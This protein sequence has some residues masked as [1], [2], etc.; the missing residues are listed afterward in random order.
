MKRKI[1]FLISG[2]IM[3]V[4]SLKSM[5][6][7]DEII[8]SM[9]N[10]FSEVPG[11]LGERIINLFQNSGYIYVFGLAIITIILNIIIIYFASKGKIVRYKELVLTF[12]IICF[13]MSLYAINELLAIINI[14]VIANTKRV[15]KEDFPEKKEKLPVL[16]K[17]DITSKKIVYAVLL[18]G[19]YFSQFIWKEFIPDNEIII[20]LTEILFYVGMFL[21]SIF[22]FKDL[23]KDNFKIFTSKFKAYMQYLL[24][25]I[26]KFYLVY[27]GISILVFSLAGSNITANQTSVEELPLFILIP[28]AII[29]APLV[30][31]CLFRGCIRRF[32]KNDKLFIVISAISF[33]L[34]HT[35][36]SEDTIYMAFVMAIP[37]ATL[38]GFLAYLYTKTN[39]ICT[40]ITFHAIQNTMA[41]IITILVKGF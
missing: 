33:G 26:G 7:A 17:E 6:Y 4:T 32:I 5:L 13:F 1:Y 12:S 30:E 31:E 15:N 20:A 3:I 14:I 41:T 9:I 35:L 34:L 22:V 29:Y 36:T 25:T 18:L 38:G 16:K 21:L 27:L 2:L 19:V 37:Y 24:P 23:L 28:L 10:T 8:N 40:N 39:N 11:S